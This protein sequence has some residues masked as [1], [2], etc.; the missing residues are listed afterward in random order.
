MLSKLAG[1]KQFLYDPIANMIHDL[2]N[3]TEYCKISALDKQ[4]CSICD[5]EEQVIEIAL[6]E[7]HVSVNKCPHCFKK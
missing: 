7:G 6:T 5:T 3:E 1:R 4:A 2:S